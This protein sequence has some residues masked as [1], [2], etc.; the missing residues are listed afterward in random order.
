MKDWQIIGRVT[1][2]MVC[3]MV[4]ILIWMCTFENWNEYAESLYDDWCLEKILCI[5]YRIWVW[6]HIIAVVGGLIAWC[7]WSWI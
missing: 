5:F 2:I 6:G 7:K 4:Y 3:A 1:S